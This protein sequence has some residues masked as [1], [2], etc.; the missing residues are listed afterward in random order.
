[1]TGFLF[2][3]T[4]TFIVKQQIIKIKNNFRITSVSLFSPLTSGLSCW[5]CIKAYNECSYCSLLVL[6]QLADPY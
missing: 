1:M 5:K 3:S 6:N 4:G 2:M